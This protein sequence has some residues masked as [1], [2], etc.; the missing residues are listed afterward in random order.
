MEKRYL[1]QYFI[2]SVNSSHSSRIYGED[3]VDN[4]CLLYINRD[5]I[6]Q[7]VGD[8]TTAW[9]SIDTDKPP[10]FEEVL[11][12]ILGLR[13][14]NLFTTSLMS[15]PNTELWGL[16]NEYM[17]GEYIEQDE[18]PSG[19][20]YFSVSEDKQDRLKDLGICVE[21]VVIEEQLR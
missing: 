13:V 17:D 19:E 10:Q 12:D 7:P 20:I 4:S 3:V 6:L 21:E 11:G 2:F 16:F 1:E 8:S 14:P 18:L 15:Y 9:A 5:N